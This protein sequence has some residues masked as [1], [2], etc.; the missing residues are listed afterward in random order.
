V[1][2]HWAQSQSNSNAAGADLSKQ[3][4]LYLREK[5]EGRQTFSIQLVGPGIQPQSGWNAPK[6]VL[7]E[8]SKSQG[9]ITLAPEQGLRL[10]LIEREAVTLMESN[11]STQRPAARNY[12]AF[13]I[14]NTRWKL[15]FDIE[16]VP[17]WIQVNTLQEVTFKEGVE[18]SVTYY[19]YNVENAGVKSLRIQVPSDAES[20]RVEGDSITD[21]VRVFPVSSSNAPQFCEV[22][23]GKRILGSYSFSVRHQRPM[24]DQPSSNTLKGA[25][26][27]GV[28]LQRGYLA[29]RSTGRVQLNVPEET[30]GLQALS[31]WQTLPAGLRAKSGE[32]APNYVFRVMDPNYALDFNWTRYTA[33]KMDQA[34]IES[35]TLS[36]V[37]SEGE[38]ILTHVR[39]EILPGDLRALEIQLPESSDFWFAFVNQQSVA[40]WSVNKTILTPLEPSAIEGEATVVEF[41][42]TTPNPYG[43]G[44]K[45]WRNLSAP[46]FGLPLENITWNIYSPTSWKLTHWGSN[47][48]YN[49]E[50]ENRESST[51]SWSGSYLETENNRQQQK[52]MEAN[53]FFNLGNTLLEKG[54]NKDAMRAYEAALNMSNNDVAFNEDARV[55]FD[56]VKMLNFANGLNQRFQNV[57]GQ[58]LAQNQMAS[59]V[60]ADESVMNAL[61]RRLVEQQAAAAILPR[62]IRA[63]LPEI[64]DKLVFER[65][66]QADSDAALKLQIRF[67]TPSAVVESWGWKL[68]ALLALFVIIGLTRKVAKSP[69]GI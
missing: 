63:S 44:F 64:G 57:Y 34:K 36:S 49:P 23:F 1:L 42:Y 60:M 58:E 3:V 67:E 27:V 32:S 29:L 10:H 26:A 41:L 53:E 51:S 66:L 13:Q 20:V 2:S 43:A 38:A 37:L 47:F 7:N 4:T 11:S 12:L 48:Q 62:A 68:G 40:P 16:Q 59:E 14:L 25:P 39:L 56:N 35:M 52:V 24:Q 5:T 9:R 28:D 17:A 69:V 50:I 65:A 18:Q 55:Q 6:L 31:D 30:V 45:S 15:G 46:K 54:Q 22:K 21:A 33:A 61:A 19:D 8:A